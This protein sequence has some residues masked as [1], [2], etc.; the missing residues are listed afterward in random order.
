MI[1]IPPS[2]RQTLACQKLFCGPE[3]R[4]L[5]TKS[6]GGQRIFPGDIPL[7][8]QNEAG[9]GFGE[10]SPAVGRPAGRPYNPITRFLEKERLA[11]PG[12]R[13]DAGLMIFA[14][15]DLASGPGNA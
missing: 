11:R 13:N 12:L 5:R 7:P 9:P 3:A 10:L 14:R 1:Q 6:L 4:T 15:N 2:L 8:P